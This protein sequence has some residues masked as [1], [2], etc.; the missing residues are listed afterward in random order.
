MKLRHIL[1]LVALVLV[2]LAATACGANTPATPTPKPTTAVA[3][4]VAA[5][6]TAPKPT[7]PPTN[8][9]TP[10]PPTATSIPAQATSK[11]LVT[12]RKG[13]GT[14]F[15]AAGQ[16]PNNT[17]AVILGKSEDAKWYQIAFPTRPRPR[18]CRWRL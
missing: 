1:F 14:Q 3:P 4:T 8:T 5:T 16:M 6:P 9:P 13:P 12:L 17:T 2:S 15:E 7:V 11:Q 18:G 10:V